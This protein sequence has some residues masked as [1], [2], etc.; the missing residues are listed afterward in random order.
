MQKPVLAI[1]SIYHCLTSHIKLFLCGKR[2]RIQDM[3]HASIFYDHCRVCYTCSDHKTLETK[4][5]SCTSTIQIPGGELRH[6]QLSQKNTGLHTAICRSNEMLTV[7]CNLR[8]CL[9]Q[10]AAAALAV[11]IKLKLL[12]LDT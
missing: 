2:T 4:W 11:L 5:C 8:S 3:S 7:W 6:L 1:N 10:K 9:P 12:Q